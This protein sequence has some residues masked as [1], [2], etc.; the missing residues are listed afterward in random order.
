[1]VSLIPQPLSLTP[2]PGG[3]VLS[4]QS[5]IA[6]TDAC[7]AEDLVPA[8]LLQSQIL[9]SLGMRLAITRVLKF[10]RQPRRTAG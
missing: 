8:Q 9:E 1:M 4:S 2:M 6:L 3:Y 7:V 5:R 10:L